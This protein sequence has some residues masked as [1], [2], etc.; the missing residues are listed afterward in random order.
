MSDSVPA[1]AIGLPIATPFDRRSFL[2]TLAAAGVMTSGQGL[3]VPAIAAD[4][5]DAKL[6]ELVADHAFHTA[7]SNELDR[8]VD[9]ACDRI[10]SPPIPEALHWRKRDFL[11]VCFDRSRLAIYR[12]DGNE[13][14]VYERENLR[15][16]A[17]LVATIKAN[18]EGF[19]G[20]QYEIERAAELFAAIEEWDAAHRR[21]EDEAGYTEPSLR[22]DREVLILRGL[23]RGVAST[24]AH[25]VEG[26][27]AKARVAA[28]IYGGSPDFIARRIA[29]HL[30]NHDYR[31]A[32][33]L[34]LIVDVMKLG[35]A[36]APAPSGA[37]V[38][39]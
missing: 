19:P 4:H 36:D 11:S 13:V 20:R 39:A 24:P 28:S 34:S 35:D 9:E 10:V 17:D 26:V 23:A 37:Q 25:T 3:D 33:G 30:D 5:P 2:A 14:H 32:I 12:I 38:A 29:G 15:G 16:L 21:S 22:A 8:L 7:Q 1:A 18:P 31:E 27:V 6:F